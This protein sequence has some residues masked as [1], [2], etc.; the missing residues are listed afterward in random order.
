M[1]IMGDP[2]MW[3]TARIFI[4]LMIEM[5]VSILIGVLIGRFL[6]KTLHTRP[7]M[8]IFWLICGIIAG[9]APLIVL[10]RQKMATTHTQKQGD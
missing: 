7:Y 6:D 10:A 4:S 5:A 3:K 1:S 9:F 8:T 2:K